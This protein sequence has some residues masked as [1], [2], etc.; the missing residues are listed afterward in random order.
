MAQRVL[1]TDVARAA[2]QQMQQIIS[3]DFEHTVQRLTTQGQTLSDPNV[4]DG[5]LA[6]QFRHDVWPK[7]DSSLKTTREGL[8]ELRAKLQ[9]INQDIM[10][11]G[12]GG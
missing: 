3:S 1:S 6:A 4:W 9:S 10:T 11:A 5:P 2:I 12:G 7:I 8:D